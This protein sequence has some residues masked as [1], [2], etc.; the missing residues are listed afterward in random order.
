MWLFVHL[1][2]PVVRGPT[3]FTLYTINM[4]KIFE[5][6]PALRI[7][8]PFLGKTGIHD[9]V[10]RMVTVPSKDL[11]KY[12]EGMSPDKKE[13]AKEL[14]RNVSDSLSDFLLYVAS[15]GTIDPD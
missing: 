13:K 10:E 14:A 9:T 7:L 5:L 8:L 15:N 2:P 11:D 3:Y 12:L 6:L 1:R 4:N